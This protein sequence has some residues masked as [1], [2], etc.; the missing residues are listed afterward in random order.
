MSG[1]KDTIDAMIEAGVREKVMVIVGGAPITERYAKD[2]GAD[3]YSDNAG[4]AA[5][6]ARSL[7]EA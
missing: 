2:I 6:L 3:G 5:R 4:G 1:M 7:L